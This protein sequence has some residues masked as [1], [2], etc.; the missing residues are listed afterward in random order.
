MMA[1]AACRCCTEPNAST[2]RKG[3]TRATP[4]AGRWR[5][6]RCGATARACVVDPDGGKSVCVP[7]LDRR[8]R[9][10]RDTTRAP[11]PA[12]RRPAR[13]GRAPRSRARAARHSGRR[14]H[15][16]RSTQNAAVPV[17]AQVRR[18]PSRPAANHAS[19]RP[20][21]PGVAAASSATA[22]P[23]EDARDP[24]APCQSRR[25]P[26]DRARVVPTRRLGRRE[27]SCARHSA[28]T[29][30]VQGM[31]RPHASR[32]P[33]ISLRM[34][35]G[36]FSGGAPGSSTANWLPGRLVAERQGRS[37]A[38]RAWPPSRARPAPSAV[39]PRTARPCRC[40]PGAA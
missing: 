13:A 33:S 6:G 25:R 27:L 30:V 39:P 21:W 37:G 36:A 7:L 14:R 22:S 24:S 15:A 19:Q 40:G 18:Q 1:T 31:S 2:S 4:A 9:A 35:A 17:S 16:E 32:R 38:G 10:A 20:R 11:S 34:T 29:R 23:N 26:P 28:R 3:V 5:A 12:A 8:S